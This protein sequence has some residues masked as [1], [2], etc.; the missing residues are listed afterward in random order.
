MTTEITELIELVRRKKY[1]NLIFDLD[2]TIT[3]LEMPWEEWIEQVTAALPPAASKKLTD[4][5]AI[6]GAPWGEIINE[7]I[8]TDSAFYEQFIAIC[9][10]FEAKHFEHTPYEALIKALPELRSQNIELFLWTSNTR[11]TAERALL[12][13]GVLHLFTQ[14][15]TR[16]D[17][18]L[19]KPDPEGWE[20]FNLTVPLSAC[21][22]IGDSQ[23]DELAAQS[24][25]V[26][27]FDIAHF[28]Q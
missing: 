20:K 25:G 3:Q 17:V 8:V 2:K 22:M 28:K 14:L 24:A 1:K 11:P 4:M 7:Q 12:E 23:N 9:R 26:A 16:E 15:L 19:G 18:K 10:N 27:Y 5:L 6:E 13:M 21:L